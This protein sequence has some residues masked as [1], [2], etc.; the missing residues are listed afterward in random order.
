MKYVV[1]GLGISG[2]SAL[3]FL[4]KRNETVIATEDDEQKIRDI[5]HSF[6]QNYPDLAKKIAF[7]TTENIDFDENTTII[8]A[9][10]IALYFPQAHK[11]LDIC[12]K[13]KATLTCDLEAFYHLNNQSNF[14]GITGTNGKSTV[15]ALVGFI[16]KELNLD[17]QVGGNIGIPCFDLPMNPKT[18]YVFEVSSYQLDLIKKLR[19]KIAALLNITPDHIDRYGNMQNYITSKRSIFKNQQSG[20]FAII[21][22]DNDNSCKIFEDFTKQQ[23]FTAHLV[24]VST[25]S[26]CNNGVSLKDKLLYNHV[27]KQNS[28]FALGEVFLKGKHNEENIASAFAISYC[29]LKQSNLLNGDSE[30][31]IIAAI[32]KFKGLEHR[33]QYVGS[34]G[35]IHFINDSKATNA[36]SAKN[37]LEYYDNIFWILGGKSKEGG[38]TDLVPYFNKIKKAFLIGQASDEFAQ[39]L[40]NHNVAFEKCETLANA[41]EKSF[42]EAK[43]HSL[44]EKNI[45][46]SPACASFDQ[47]K[48]F[49]QRGEFFCNAFHDLQNLQKD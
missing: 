17:V 40:Q 31:K 23:N 30:S 20:D 22:I 28:R 26:I 36:I 5:A 27:A 46:L 15:T 37:A 11:I 14:I 10:G 34:I 29:Y 47:W 8:F 18:T 16:L 45:L 2:I 25:D 24:P 35:D 33:M 38:I 19:F 4:A 43:N 7:L 1:Y 42:L 32:Q 48:N 49:E 9:P 44:K 12:K 6:A 3:K 21:N 41:M 39:V 13:T